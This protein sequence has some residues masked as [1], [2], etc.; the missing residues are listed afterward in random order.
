MVGLFKGLID[1]KVRYIELTQDKVA[2]IDDEDFDLISKRRWVSLNSKSNK[3][4]W[5]ARAVGK[6][7][8]VNG[9]I[10]TVKSGEL[11]HRLI[12]GITDP[13]VHVD[14]INGDGLD[15]RKQNL[16]IATRSQNSKNKRAWGR[17]KYLGVHF[18]DS[19]G[20][21]NWR[22][23]ICIKKA[24]KATGQKRERISRRFLTEIDAAKGYDELAKVYHGEFANLNFK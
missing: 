19:R 10:V 7:K 13:A 9:R 23:E 1:I 5:Y 17:S 22:I 15:N 21:K 16:R 8:R 18:D 6:S 4:N 20:K 2:I 12:L 14:H 11:M 24:N 3:H